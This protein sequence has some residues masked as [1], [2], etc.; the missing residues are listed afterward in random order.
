VAPVH[1]WTFNDGTADDVVGI[2]D[3]VLNGGASISSGS[4]VLDGIDGFVSTAP[5]GQDLGTRTLVVWVT[6]SNLL[7][8]GGGV[9]TLQDGGT[10][11]GLGHGSFIEGQWLATSEGF[12][13]TPFDNGGAAETSATR[14]MMAIIHDGNVGST[15]IVR[16][17]VRYGERFNFG[18]VGYG[19]DAHVLFGVIQDNEFPGSADG[20]DAF[21][22]GAIDE[23]R[24]YDRV[25][26]VRELQ[27]LDALGPVP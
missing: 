17:G 26:T 12:N 4:L 27:Q 13:R 18:T 5:T 7:Q 19:T 22:A 6:P 21:F 16:D 25:L 20:F 24:V 9:L 15:T 10:F 2:A 1:Q 14:H 3:G 23:A 11:D 8:R